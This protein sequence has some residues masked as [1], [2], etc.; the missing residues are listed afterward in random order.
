MPAGQ[1]DH[2]S[3]NSSYSS[4]HAPH[5][6]N[7]STASILKS[8]K[9]QDSRGGPGSMSSLHRDQPP[10]TYTSMSR[11]PYMEEHGSPHSPSTPTRFT[12]NHQ[13]D[14]YSSNQLYADNSPRYS[15]ASNDSFNRQ[16]ENQ[17]HSYREDPQSMGFNHPGHADGH[18]PYGSGQHLDDQGYGHPP[19]DQYGGQPNYVAHGDPQGGDSFYRDSPVDRYPPG[20]QG[21]PY[22]DS[23]GQ[24][25]PMTMDNR[26]NDP[27][28]MDDRYRGHH[29]DDSVP[30]ERFQNMSLN[31]PRHGDGR[32]DDRGPVDDMHGGPPPNDSF[33][34]RP[35]GDSYGQDP[36]FGN[37]DDSPYRKHEGL[38]QIHSDPFA[39]DPFQQKAAM[40][41]DRYPGMPHDHYRDE[42]PYHRGGLPHPDD[43]YR[44][45]GPHPDDQ[46]RD[47]D[48]L[49]RR[50]P[51][52]DRYRDEDPYSRGPPPP[53]DGYGDD[54]YSR[55]PPP[56]GDRYMQDPYNRRTPS[57][58]IDGRYDDEQPPHGYYDD[59]VRRSQPHLNAAPQDSYSDGRR[60]PSVQGDGS[61]W[62]P[63]DLQ[64]VIDYLNTPV[65]H[66]KANAAA[67]L[68][69]LCFNDDDMKAKARGM[70]A[71][72]PLIDLI[73]SDNPEV[74]R[75]ACG[76]L[77]NLSFG[78]GDTGL[79][80][81]K[82]IVDAGGIT[83]LIRLLRRAQDEE[84]KELATGILWNLSSSEE[85]K[86]KIIAE[87][88]PEIVSRVIVPYSGWEQRGLMQNYE[89]WTTVYKNATGI[90][91]NLS[92]ANKDDE[93]KGYDTRNKLREC[94]KLVNCLV[95][96]LKI[97]QANKDRESKP[98]ENCTCALRNLSFRIQEVVEQDFY[99]KRTLTLKKRQ[100]PEKKDSPG[101]FGGGGK[102]KDQK[103]KGKPDLNQ[104]AEVQLPPGAQEFQA[105]WQPEAVSLYID[106][107]KE[108]SNPVTVEAAAGA[109][110]NLTACYWKY[111]DEIRSLV[112]KEKGLPA[113]VDLLGQDRDSVVC[114]SALALRNLAI[115]E[116]NK[117]L[118]GKYAMKQITFTLP[119]EKQ[120]ESVPD[121]TVCAVVALLHE[122]VKN[123][124]DFAQLFTAEGGIVRLKFVKFSRGK[125]LNR[126]KE[127]TQTLLNALWE[128]KTLHGEYAQYGMTEQDF[129]REPAPGRSPDAVS[130][131]SNF[132]T[133]YSTMS[134][135]MESQGYDDN[136]LSPG[137][138]MNKPYQ[139]VN[140]RM[141]GYHGNMVQGH[142]NPAMN[143][144]EPHGYDDRRRGEDIPMSDI[145]PGYAPLEERRDRRPPVGGVP[146][147]PAL[148]PQGG[149][150][151]PLYAQVNKNKRKD[152]MGPPSPNHVMLGDP[153]S[154]Q[155]GAD[156]WV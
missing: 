8:V 83:A 135:P 103:A 25:G 18:Y 88:L 123:S 82:Q 117:E 100:Q 105:L 137:R 94:S 32:Y 92:S 75:N 140:G 122:V 20:D 145:A 93:A 113:L 46:Y 17:Y 90:I 96:T 30:E 51:G 45:E 64:E 149:P 136:T 126:T 138:P 53:D 37:Y 71:I 22:N 59:N 60:T 130:P 80:N 124:V 109:I 29:P 118:I 47:D 125:F 79:R 154:P 3:F 33:D 89:P 133:P 127:H 134:R 52:D 43:R 55:G 54:P 38:P 95:Y 65:D 86:G 26:A 31:D 66:I 56:Q 39:D 129:K 63:P 155:G 61:S 131:N 156:S 114:H 147:F 16:M 5:Y 12:P 23:Y 42:D 85:L 151:E 40:E 87:G 102:K 2:N 4:H 121:R 104:N 108:S 9:A 27:S 48:T 107:L 141:D 99:K 73:N 34:N 144:E 41:D 143:M 111:A 72:P 10:A 28:Y 68:Q 91:R 36:S 78:K 150:G 101:C 153:N 106:I 112:R 70:G 142:S 115:D 69:H 13:Y 148:Q 11:P 146:L 62:R 132:N 77:K 7:E 67:Y 84:V 98:V 19:P 49:Q 128:F 44:E 14:P 76:V 139:P 21:D 74:Q 152:D 24:P 81:K 15:M 50:P 58:G 119:M 120:K 97:S 6:A 57:P 116:K 110:Q 35:P 1:Y